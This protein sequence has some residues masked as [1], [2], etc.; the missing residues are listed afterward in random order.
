MKRFGTEDYFSKFEFTKPYQL[1]SSDCESINITEL[2]KMGGGT[3]EEFLNVK[4]GYPEM[5]GG[6]PLRHEVS[7]LYSTVNEDQVMILGS[8]IEGIYLSMQV[9]LKKNDHVVVLSPA[10]DALYNV[11]E[12]LCGNVSRWYLK[13]DGLKWFLDFDQLV[14]VLRANTKLLVLNFPHN[15]TGYIPS[16]KDISRIIQ[17][18]TKYGVLIFSDEI[19]YGLELNPN[20]CFKSIADQ[21]AHCVTMSGASKGLGLPGLRFGWLVVKD[22]HLYDQLLSLK[23]Y[24]SMCAHQTNEYLG[25]M[26]IRA[27]PQLLVKNLMIIGENL[28]RAETFFKKHE[29]KFT[30]LRPD[31]GSISVF[32]LNE[33]SA[34]K[35]CHNL[36][37]KF[38]VVLLPILHMGFE[39]QF[40]RMG[41]GRKSF[42]SSLEVFD[43][44][45]DSILDF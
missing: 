22:P 35:F 2:I 36:A 45:M 20:N 34:D 5:P 33:G 9:V 38:G 28:K 42:S 43:Q 39:D 11:A 13:N 3:T 30:W 37:E 18:C 31:G 15:P 4:L 6:R 26:A 12:H 16:Q 25:V 17:I 19:Y 1:A 8:P 23:T 27:A 14:S 41:F 29:S 7:Q 44:A 24:T 10:Y 40:V 21:T 32:K